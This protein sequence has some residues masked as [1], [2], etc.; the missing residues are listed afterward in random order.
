[1]EDSIGQGQTTWNEE[2]PIA[3]FD[4]QRVQPHLNHPSSDFMIVQN[5]PKVKK[6]HQDDL[7][8]TYSWLLFI[9][10]VKLYRWESLIIRLTQVSQFVVVST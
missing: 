5:Q 7:W 4:Y 3:M 6:S 2:F 10:I 9:I 8:V 1:M